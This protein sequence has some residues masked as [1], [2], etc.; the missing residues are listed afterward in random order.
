MRKFAIGS[1]VPEDLGWTWSSE[2]I[3]PPKARQTFLNLSC[4]DGVVDMS[5]VA[6]GKLLYNDRQITVTFARFKKKPDGWREDADELAKRIRCLF[7]AGSHEVS[8]TTKGTTKAYTAYAWDYSVLRDGIVQFVEFVFTCKAIIPVSKSKTVLSTEAVLTLRR[9]EA[10][11]TDFK[12][13]LNDV[14]AYNSSNVQVDETISVYDG[15][16]LVYSGKS[17]A[18]QSTP[19]SIDMSP[20]TSDLNL[21]IVVSNMS[22]WK[23]VFGWTKEEM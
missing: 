16:T 11:D 7:E 15:A 2:S 23:V 4:A 10:N 13:N 20:Y 9:D 8:I 6:A 14:K 12:I 18:Y 21:N 19:F 17:A 3:D 5:R 22:T 1:V